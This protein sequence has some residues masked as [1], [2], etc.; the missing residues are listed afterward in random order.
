MIQKFLVAL[1]L[2]ALVLG[3]GCLPLREDTTTMSVRLTWSGDGNCDVGIW[4][5]DDVKYW[6]T[7]RYTP[8]GIFSADDL[9]GGPEIWTLD[10][11]HDPGIYTPIARSTT[12][13][14][15]I[16]IQITV[17]DVTAY[18]YETINPGDWLYFMDYHITRG[19]A[20]NTLQYNLVREKAP[21]EPAAEE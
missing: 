8:N 5:P 12:C 9:Y 17:N 2:L 19:P 4:E 21:P 6:V 15:T 16:T 14:G 20:G 11:Y 3:G 10:R 7:S 18:G 1:S 13:T